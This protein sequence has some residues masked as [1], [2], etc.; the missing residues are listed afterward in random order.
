M[1]M[2]TREFWRSACTN[3]SAYISYFTRLTQ[4]AISRFEWNNLPTTCDARYLELALFGDGQAIF[5]FDPYMGYLTL[6]ML[7]NGPFNEYGYP[8]ERVGYGYSGSFQIPANDTN[9]VIIYNNMLRTND[10]FQIAR[11]SERLYDLDQTIDINA[12]AQKTPLLL[13]CDDKE[14]LA[15][16]NIYM[17]YTGN[18]PVIYG[19]K[20]LSTASIQTI[21]TGAQYVA[22]KIYN[23]RNEIWNEALTYL[24][25]SNINITKKERLITDE[26]TR[27]M[28]G[29]MASLQSALFARQQACEKINNLFGL[30]ISCTFRAENF[31]PEMVVDDDEF[32]SE[33]SNNL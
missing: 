2:P 21:N 20:P 9:S 33:D 27:H 4:I 30:N 12:K 14:R 29:T 11:F 3:N 5:L 6:R 16:K 10:Q 28:G 24:G 25:V 1:N 26:V 15:L 32:N 31:N 18:T 22:D 13:I 23:L 19:T 7:A 8:T 17:K